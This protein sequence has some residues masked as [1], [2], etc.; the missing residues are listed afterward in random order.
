[1]LVMSLSLAP[2]AARASDDSVRQVVQTE[3]ARQVKEDAKFRKAVKTLKTKAQFVK[4]RTATIRQMKSVD[5]FHDALAAQQADSATVKAGRSQILKGMTRYNHGLK[6]FRTALTK[7]IN[8]NGREGA[9]QARAALKTVKK[10]LKTIE[11]GAK[12][13]AG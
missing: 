9:P 13:L 5:K 11:S 12:K 8:S 4:A 3:A 10:A 1:M 7:G 2:A 6:K